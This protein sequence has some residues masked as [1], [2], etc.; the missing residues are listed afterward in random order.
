MLFAS[1]SDRKRRRTAF[2]L[3]Q[4]RILPSFTLRQR[5]T[6]ITRAIVRYHFH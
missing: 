6:R 2:W 4:Q 3:L 5:S 1:T